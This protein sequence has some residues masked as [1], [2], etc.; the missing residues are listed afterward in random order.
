MRFLSPPGVKEI[1]YF[2]VYFSKVPPDTGDPVPR[3]A[4]ETPGQ[5]TGEAPSICSPGLWACAQ[6]IQAQSRENVTGRLWICCG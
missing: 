5:E 6:Q 2:G 3:K 4:R 1:T